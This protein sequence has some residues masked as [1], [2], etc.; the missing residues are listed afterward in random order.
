MREIVQL[1]GIPVI[2]MW[3]KDKGFRSQFC[4]SLQG[5]FKDSSYIQL[6]LSLSEKSGSPTG[7]FRILIFFFYPNSLINSYQICID[8]AS[9]EELYSM[10]YRRCLYFDY[11]SVNLWALPLVIHILIGIILVPIFSMFILSLIEI[12]RTKFL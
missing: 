10:K 6:I 9:F 7:S 11:C 5:K 4:Q 12:L 8:L 3:D 1:H 2:I